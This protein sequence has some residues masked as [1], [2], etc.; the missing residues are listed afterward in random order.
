MRA[1]LLVLALVGLAFSAGEADVDVHWHSYTD[2]LKKAAKESKLMFVSLYADW[3]VPCRIMEKN[4]YPEPSVAKLLNERFVA[5]RLNVES[6]DTIKCDGLVKTVERCYFDVWNLSAVP[7][8]V[9]VAPKGMSI[10]T[11]TQSMDAE[12]MR[13]LLNQFLI[14]EKEWIAQ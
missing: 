2:G 5:V 6:K 8:L 4:V 13:Y 10:L 1:L 9:L 3:C 11:L 14:K 7:S 12:E